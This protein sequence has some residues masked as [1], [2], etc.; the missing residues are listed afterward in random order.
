MTTMARVCP[1]CGRGLQ[2]E[3]HGMN[4]PT[5]GSLFSGIGGFDLGLERAGW[6]VKWQVE[7]NPYRQKVLARHWP[8]VERRTD[9]RTDTN[10]LERVDLI[11]GGFPCQ[12]LSVA[13]K[14][15]GLAGERSALFFDFAR[16]VST[17]KPRWV[18]VEN[19]PGLLNSN[20]GRDFAIVLNQLAARRYGLAW[21]VLDSQH[22][23]VPQRRRRVYIVGHLGA[24]CPPEILFEPESVCGDAS[25]GREAGATVASTLGGGSGGRGWCDDFDR[26]GGFIEVA[27]PLQTRSPGNGSPERSDETF[28]VNA[29]QDPVVSR[30]A[31]PLD[32][33][34]NSQAIAGTV[35]GAEGH[36]G[37][38]NPIPENSRHAVAYRKRTSPHGGEAQD[39]QWEEAA[40][41]DILTVHQTPTTVVAETLRVGGRAQGAGSSY[42]NT[43]IVASSP[44]DPDGVRAPTGISRRLDTPDSPRYAALGDAVTVP[45]I[46][47]IGRRLLAAHLL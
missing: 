17:V 31:Q 5:V 45:V 15:A 7:H 19:V 29:R 4:K 27:H 37:N 6:D 28:V 38:S 16:L 36:N 32:T 33:D 24:P 1:K 26:S 30:V 11:C 39:E 22:F 47:W 18:L 46:E 14:R 10:G 23:G 41:A 43:P 42:D 21:R 8:D 40:R 34:G 35:T 44:P 20:D 25:T 3:R 9:I 12:D 2:A 13:G